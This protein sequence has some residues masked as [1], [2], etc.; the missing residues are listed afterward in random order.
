MPKICLA[1]Y[2]EGTKCF[3]HKI[4]AKKFFR[5]KKMRDPRNFCV[6]LYTG[7]DIISFLETSNIDISLRNPLWMAK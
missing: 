1:Q 7:K 5:R 2:F 6:K 3:I 4:L